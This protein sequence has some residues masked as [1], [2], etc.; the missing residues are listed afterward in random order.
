MNPKSHTLFHFT[1]NTEILKNIIKEGFWPRYCLEDIGWLG[2]GSNFEYMAYPLVSFCDIPLARIDEH[3]SFYGEYGIGLTRQWAEI[4][5][6]NPIHYIAGANHVKKSIRNN[7]LMMSEYE[8][9]ENKK[10]S[11]KYWKYL[12]A[13]MKPTEGN[14][15]V[16]GA[17]VQKE[18]Y[19]ESEW[20]Y[21]PNSESVTEVLTRTEYEDEEA[22]EKHNANVKAFASL[23][24]TPKDIKYIFVKDDANIPEI[25]NFIQNELDMFPSADLKVLMS[26]VTS[27]KTIRHDL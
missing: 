24:F 11:Q 27:L 3:V 18:F 17:L 19:Q 15:V 16:S 9:E 2:G 22:R 21:V 8:N 6:L 4:N 1:K 14:M 7:I 26:R 10:K 25:I 20:R 13:Y 23:K 5:N 12:L